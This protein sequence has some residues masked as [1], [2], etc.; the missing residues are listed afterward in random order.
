MKVTNH[1]SLI[2]IIIALFFLTMKIK[3]DLDFYHFI[4]LELSDDDAQPIL[5]A[6][7]IKS[8]LL[9]SFPMLIALAFSIIGLKRQNKFRIFALVL[10]IITMIY[11]IIPVGV[12]LAT[13]TKM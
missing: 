13:Q 5:F 1:F 10:N 7:K 11:L 4:K 9:Y 3:I 6:S 8:S 12:I 2:A